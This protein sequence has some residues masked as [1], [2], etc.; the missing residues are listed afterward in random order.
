VKNIPGLEELK[1]SLIYEENTGFFLRAIP[2]PGLGKKIGDRA[3]CVRGGSRYITI[4]GETYPEAAVAWLFSTGKYPDFRIRHKNG[5]AC[6][7]RICNLEE[8]KPKPQITL[9][10]K[11]FYVHTSVARKKVYLGRYDSYDEAL[12]AF[13]GAREVLFGEDHGDKTV[14]WPDAPI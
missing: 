5:D 7:N 11:M 12:A 8:I 3:G 10:G 9:I 14:V 6:D 13:Y 1:K 4:H 2:R